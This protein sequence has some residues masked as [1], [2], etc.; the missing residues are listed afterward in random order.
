MKCPV[1]TQDEEFIPT[2]I[3]YTPKECLKEECVWWGTWT[4]EE[5]EEQTGCCFPVLTS[6]LSEIM[7]RMTHS[8]EE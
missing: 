8:K 7:W 4:T 5:S 3:K 2:G 1:L 6:I